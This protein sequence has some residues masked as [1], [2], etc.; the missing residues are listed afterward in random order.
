MPPALHS[1]FCL[2]ARRSSL[3]AGM[4]PL[5]L[6]QLPAAPPELACVAMDALLAVQLRHPAAFVS[7]AEQGGVGQVSLWPCSRLMERMARFLLRSVGCSLEGL[8]VNGNA[9]WLYPG[10]VG[11]ASPACPA[12]AQRHPLR[13]AAWQP[14]ERSSHPLGNA[15][16]ATFNAFL[17]PPPQHLPLLLLPHPTLPTGQVCQLLREQGTPEPVR[18]HAVQFLNLLLSQVRSLACGRLVKVFGTSAC[19]ALVHAR[20][21]QHSHAMG[22][23]SSRSAAL[24]TAARQ[25]CLP[26]KRHGVR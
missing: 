7:F 8:Q 22:R 9:G 6:A 15:G 23:A 10:G 21:T 19:A 3:D 4:L 18:S 26:R 11:L 2:Q 5:L 14:G 1:R 20:G 25:L 13:R 12:D 24:H 16:P 17:C